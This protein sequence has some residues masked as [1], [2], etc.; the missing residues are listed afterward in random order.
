MKYLEKI[1]ENKSSLIFLFLILGYIVT[2]FSNIDWFSFTLAFIIGTLF[3]FYIEYNNSK[4]KV[5]IFLREY[6]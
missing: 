4:S 6:F 5:M 3:A 2:S 1:V